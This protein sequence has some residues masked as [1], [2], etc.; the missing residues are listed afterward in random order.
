MQPVDLSHIISPSAIQPE[1][2]DSEQNSSNMDDWGFHSEQNEND[3]AEAHEGKSG[4][5]AGTVPIVE[6]PAEDV[7]FWGEELAEQM[8]LNQTPVPAAA[9]VTAPAVSL[10]PP[11]SSTST[12][13]QGKRSTFTLS[14]QIPSSR[15]SGPST[16]NDEH[17]AHVVKETSARIISTFDT[18]E[19]V[20]KE[21][22]VARIVKV[23]KTL[24]GR[25]LRRKTR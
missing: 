20:E 12:Q 11:V 18:R 7:A 24:L 15:E 3:I 23:T 25:G 6:L 10:P 4:T 8:Y 16:G 2:T 9:T 13:T 21:K 17:S 5:Y 14:A 22:E 19:T 1:D